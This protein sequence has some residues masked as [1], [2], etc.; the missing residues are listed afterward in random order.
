M[1]AYYLLH[2]NANLPT[3]NDALEDSSS[4]NKDSEVT[5]V[6]IKQLAKDFRH[7]RSTLDFDHGYLQDIVT[8]KVK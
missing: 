5:Y 4:P 8:N 6:K 1:Q 3:N 2:K 7:H